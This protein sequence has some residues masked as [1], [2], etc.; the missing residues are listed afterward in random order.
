[1][2]EYDIKNAR[3]G[4]CLGRL[5]IR[6]DQPHLSWKPLF[7]LHDGLSYFLLVPSNISISFY[8]GDFICISGALDVPRTPRDAHASLGPGTP[9]NF[10]GTPLII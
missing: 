8:M 9:F 4:F 7:R 6:P 1:M 10:P 2:T 3:Q 5:L